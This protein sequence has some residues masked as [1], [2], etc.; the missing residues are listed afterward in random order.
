M[1]YL[2]SILMPF[3]NAFAINAI[4][5]PLSIFI[6]L[7]LFLLSIN[8][9]KLK[10]NKKNII[11]LFLILLSFTVT[12]INGLKYQSEDYYNQFFLYLLPI[13]LFFFAPYVLFNITKPTLIKISQA[14]FYALLFVSI[15]VLIEFLLKNIFYIEIKLPRGSV[16]DFDASVAFINV[17]RPRGFTEESG[18]LALYISIM[19]PLSLLYMKSMSKLKFN[20]LFL[21]I[22]SSWFVTFSIASFVSYTI[23]ASIIFLLNF[24]KY[25]S[26]KYYLFI[27]SFV[28]LSLIIMI[29]YLAEFLLNKLNSISFD[30]RLSRILDSLNILKS[31]DFWD[32][33]F[34]FGPGYYSY[35][36]VASP[37]NFYL[38][39]LMAY[40]IVGV[41]I[42][43]TFSF[44]LLYKASKV[45]NFIL[46][47]LIASLFHYMFISN[48]WYPWFWWLTYT[49]IYA[50]NNKER[51]L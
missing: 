37:I 28:I 49:I 31:G 44:N 46:F 29:P 45:S 27:F 21:I 9:T 51:G 8:I 42:F 33:S 35:F 6:F 30:E 16:Q 11:Y 43:L 26:S 15:F 12:L 22:F 48:I 50:Y 23:A 17:Y 5:S 1:I 47:P 41:I 2:Y 4:L 3:V 24:K 18:H 20:L 25:I 19:F 10:I 39:L 13:F 32:I 36:G 40:G 7:M 34:G 38:S 14:S